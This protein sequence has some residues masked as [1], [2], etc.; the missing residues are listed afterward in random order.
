MTGFEVTKKQREIL[1]KAT[2]EYEND[3]SSNEEMMAFPSV[4]TPLPPPITEPYW[5]QDADAYFLLPYILFDSLGQHPTF[6]SK[7]RKLYRHLC[8]EDGRC[9]LLSRG[10]VNEWNN[11][12]KDRSNP[13]MLFDVESPVLLVSKV[14]KCEHGHDIPASYFHDTSEDYTCVPFVLTHRSGMTMRLADEI[15]DLLDRGLAISAVEELIKE[16]YKRT[17][18]NRLLRFLND[19]HQAKELGFTQS[20]EELNFDVPGN[21]F[22]WPGD[23]FIRSVYVASFNKKK[24]L[25]KEQ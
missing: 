4:V 8:A 11:A 21:L 5:R 14:Y 23:N 6:R 25:F 16:R 10:S 7:K 20:A 17:L 9:S 18:R 24:H 1:M 12:R 15:E 2:V 19:A 13:R 22:P 3:L